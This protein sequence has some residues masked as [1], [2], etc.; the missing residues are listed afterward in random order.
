MLAA[1]RRARLRAARLHVLVTAALCRRAWDETAEQA[2]RGG[3]DVV[4]LREKD[5]PDGELLARAVRLVALARSHSALAIVNDRPDIARLADADGVHVGQTDLPAAAA[6]AVVGAA[7]LVG[8]STHTR[9]QVR[10]ALADRPDYVAVGPMFSSQTKPRAETA[11]PELAAAAL[12]EL[13]AA[14]LHDLP[15][16]AIGGV[17][18]ERVAEL[19]RAGVR[20]VAVC[21]AVIGAG[22]PAAACAALRAALGE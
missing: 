6:R 7:R 16:V 2:L 11:G 18:L 13:G 14:D 21:Q 8:V 4:Q 15:L 1:P 3:A 19:R 17:A 10:A 20:C 22:D 5:L 9:E 12:S